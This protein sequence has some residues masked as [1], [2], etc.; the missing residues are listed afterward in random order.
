MDCRTG[1]NVKSIDKDGRT[2]STDTGETFAWDHLVL[3]TGSRPRRLPEAIGGNLSG[4][5]TLRDVNDADQFAD[6]LTEGRKV[7]IVGGGYIGLEAAAVCASKGL[8]VTLVEAAERILQRV[9]CPET[10]T[11][12]R[13]LHTEKGVTI[14]EGVGLERIEAENARAAKVVLS[15]GEEL[16]ADF[17]L[18]GIGIIPN[19]ELAGEAGLEVDG[20][21]VTDNH[22]RT[23]HPDIYAAET[24]PL[25]C[26]TV[27]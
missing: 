19:A 17:V 25:S 8:D 5:Y 2:V 16:A 12:F 13:N 7:V 6:E 26:M 11:W 9:A 21:I 14:H 24:V 18:V 22:C 20:G 23:S 1:I 10:S 15:N 4:V 27:S 3:T